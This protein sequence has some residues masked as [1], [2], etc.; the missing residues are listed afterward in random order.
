MRSACGRGVSVATPERVEAG[1]RE[2]RRPWPRAGEGT[3]GDRNA[4]RRNG[5]RLHRC[6]CAICPLGP[7]DDGIAPVECAFARRAYPKDAKPTDVRVAAAGTPP[8]RSKRSER[9]DV[10]RVHDVLPCRQ[11]SATHKNLSSIVPAT[12]LLLARILLP[13]IRKALRGYAHTARFRAD[14]RLA[15]IFHR[16]PDVR[17]ARGDTCAP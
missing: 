6:R 14:I 2:M 4:R 17:Q 11:F 15:E 7:H 1:R 3:R 8:R 10:A 5:A 13:V 9:S 16:G 12:N